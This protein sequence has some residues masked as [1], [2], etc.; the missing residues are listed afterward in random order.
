MANE[1]HLLFKD[2]FKF[3][4]GHKTASYKLERK[5]KYFIKTN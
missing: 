3:M 5:A 4:L 2:I 1:V